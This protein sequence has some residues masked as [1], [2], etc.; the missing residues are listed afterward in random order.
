MIDALNL[1]TRRTLLDGGLIDRD[2]FDAMN[3]AYRWYVP[4]RGFDA[5]HEE[6]MPAEAA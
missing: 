1:K 2:T 6:S 3:A 4:L 5:E